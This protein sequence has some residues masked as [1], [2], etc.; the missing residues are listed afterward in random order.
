MR[1]VDTHCHLQDAK[2]DDDRAAV[3]ARALDTLDGIVLIGDTVESSRAAVALTRE[4]VYAAVGVHPYHPD[5]IS[6]ETLSAL[7]E[8]ASNRYVVAIGEI[9]LDYYKYNE[10]PAPLQQA[11]FHAQ[12]ELAADL[13]LP[14]AIHNRDAEADTLSILA[15]HD[16]EI[17]GVIMHC[18]SGDAAFAERC[19]GRGY[20]VSF[21][22]NV[23]YPKAGALREAAA[24]VPMDRLLLET[25]SPY[26][27]PQPVR[28]RR[29]E[30]AFVTHT[31]E[32]LA[33]VKN[34]D[35]QELVER[36]TDNAMRVF[37]LGARR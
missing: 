20:Y 33:T 36:T 3:M 19:S 23:T 24:V 6:A 31:A 27:A 22:G 13:S 35:V 2:F 15:E 9:G 4:N 7:T 1:L 28:G 12:L 26:L 37:R 11:A 30:P 14:V 17:P 29:C 5:E 34:V 32:T 25:D 18:F 8:L 10:A 16:A 21:A